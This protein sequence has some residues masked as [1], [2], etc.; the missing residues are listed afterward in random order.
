MS[1]DWSRLDS[2]LDV[3]I[4]IGRGMRI[5][6]GETCR[7]TLCDILIMLSLSPSVRPLIKSRQI[8]R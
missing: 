2:V 3:L 4:G 6:K 7:W 8:D 5:E 1:G